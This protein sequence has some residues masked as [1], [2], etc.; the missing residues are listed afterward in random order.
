[1]PRLRGPGPG[2]RAQSRTER[3]VELAERQR[4]VIH[5]DQLR[6]LG[7]SGSAISRWEAA[8]R[9]HRL[10]PSVYALGHRALDEEGRMRAALLYAGPGAVLSHLA[11]AWVW[12][13]VDAEPSSI[14]M[15]AT[16]EIT[17]QPGLV[18][19][20]RRELE[21][22][23]H[24]LLP[25]TSPRLTVLDAA[26][27]LPFSR[28]RRALAEAEYRRLVTMDEVAGVLGRGRPGS[29]ALRRA[30]VLHQP[31]LART[32]SV[33]EERFLSLC[34]RFSVPMPEVNVRVCGFT[35]DAFWR[36]E[37]VVVE[38]DGRTAH[39]SDERVEHDRAR[40]LALRAA[41]HTV[42]RYTW[43]QVSRQAGAVAA[44][45]RAALG[46]HPLGFAPGIRA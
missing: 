36:R 2:D 32:R 18:V 16:R 39:G 26:S 6:A 28:L 14:D 5:R 27:V 22:A 21:V 11:A 3:I 19:H 8:G 10:Y 35:V 31:R 33:L 24:R 38:L 15:S 43:N 34:E 4:G 37:R 23:T 20:R 40:D 12:E 29:G 44:D 42:L 30:M 41:G 25:V 45:L 7:L 13:I 1:M 9:I 17:A 46:L